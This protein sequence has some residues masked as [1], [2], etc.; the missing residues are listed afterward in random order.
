VTGW[1]LTWHLLIFEWSFRCCHCFHPS[2]ASHLCMLRLHDA[3]LGLTWRHCVTHLIDFMPLF[4]TKWLNFLIA[5]YGS[6]QH[7]AA[8]KG[9]ERW[10]RASTFDSLTISARIPCTCVLVHLHTMFAYMLVCLQVRNRL[11]ITPWKSNIQPED[12]S[13]QKDNWGVYMNDIEWI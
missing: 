2:R 4:S 12:G 5:A 9:Q 13:S 11:F 1:D 8:W 3:E 6:E 10:S 7:T